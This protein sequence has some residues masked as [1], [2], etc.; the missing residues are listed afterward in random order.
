MLYICKKNQQ[1][2]SWQSLDCLYRCMIKYHKAA[3]TVFM[4]M[5]I[6]LFETCQKQYN[7]IK[8]LMKRV[9]ILLVL[10]IYMC[11]HSEAQIQCRLFSKNSQRKFLNIAYS[12][13]VRHIC[14]R[15]ISQEELKRYSWKNRY[16]LFVLNLIDIFIFSDLISISTILHLGLHRIFKRSDRKS[17]NVHRIVIYPYNLWRTMKT[18]VFF[19]VQPT[20][21]F[22]QLLM[23]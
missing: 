14:P 23:V 2:T 13:Y 8:T 7:W 20:R 16:S 10:F 18:T 6:W 15:V 3:C 22:Q 21:S 17:Q 4:T 5:D 9:C 11:R 12:C 19:R 1:N